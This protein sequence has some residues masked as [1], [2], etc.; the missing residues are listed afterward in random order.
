MPF[1]WSGIDDSHLRLGVRPSIDYESVIDNINNGRGLIPT[2]VL[3]GD[4][5]PHIVELLSDMFYGN[6]AS[7]LFR[8]FP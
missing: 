7:S 3:K 1:L 4:L 8:Q 2:S 5:R 6:H